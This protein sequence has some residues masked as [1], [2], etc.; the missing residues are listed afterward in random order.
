MPVPAAHLSLATV[1]TWAKRLAKT[2]KQTDPK[3]PWPLARC[4]LAVATMLGYD[5]WHALNHALVEHEANTSTTR[6]GATGL[7][8]EGGRQD[9]K[10]APLPKSTSDWRPFLSNLLGLDGLGGE[11]HF[12]FRA[13]QT[14]LRVRRDGVIAESYTLA[15]NEAMLGL[16][17]VLDDETR[18][19]FEEMME[20]AV[21]S[22]AP[23]FDE[24]LRGYS[25]LHDTQGRA[26]RVLG[27]PIY[28][29][30][31]D[32]VVQVKPVVPGDATLQALGLPAQ[33]EQSLRELCQ[34]QSGVF[35]FTGTAGS[36]KSTAMVHLIN[37]RV[38]HARG[39]RQKV[40][41]V[42]NPTEYSVRGGVNVRVDPDRGSDGMEMTT[43]ALLGVGPDILMLGEVRDAPTARGAFAAAKAGVAVYSS[44]HA[45]QSSL[46]QRMEDLEVAAMELNDHLV[47]WAYTKLLPVLCPHC[48]T[49]MPQIQGLRQRGAGCRQCAG[50]G[51]FGRQLIVD[52]WKYDQ[53]VGRRLHSCMDQ[54]RD[55]VRNGDVAYDDA[56]EHLGPLGL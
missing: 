3:H 14:T 45:S 15:T 29:K 16:A 56:E 34:F 35:F 5:H 18:P 4:Q 49:P 43:R 10:I 23:H 42:Q 9:D 40:Y 27:T 7:S 21:R 54:A 38:G 30:G 32:V 47:G 25:A 20:V 33:V 12:A 36:G 1:K 22:D 41:T 11:V 50:T 6:A 44:C 37:D 17:S 52:L 31:L 28:P 19:Q 2:S 39:K 46:P 51:V 13:N 53:G 26:A 8:R 24:Y 48:S 55:L